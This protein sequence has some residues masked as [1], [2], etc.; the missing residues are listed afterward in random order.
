MYQNAFW[1]ESIT[2]SGGGGGG[3]GD[4]GLAEEDVITIIDEYVTKPYV[5]NL[6]IPGEP[7]T[8]VPSA[9]VPGNAAVADRIEYGNAAELEQLWFM[10][11]MGGMGASL[12]TNFNAVRQYTR[13]QDAVVEQR[14]ANT[15]YQK[16]DTVRLAQGL[17]LTYVQ[18]QLGSQFPSI[19]ADSMN[20]L[21]CVTPMAPLVPPQLFWNY[22]SWDVASLTGVLQT[23]ERAEVWLLNE[24]TVH[25]CTVILWDE[26][27]GNSASG[28]AY[29]SHM[30][31]SLP[32]YSVGVN[33]RCFDIPPATL[34]R[35]LYLRTT[36]RALANQYV[37][38]WALT[39]AHV[40]R[41]IQADNADA[42]GGT[43]ATGFYLK[44]DTV[45]NAAQA[46]NAQYL[47]GVDASG[48]LRT[49][50][51][52][53][54]AIGAN[55]S[56]SA[57]TATSATTAADASKLGGVSPSGYYL[58]TDT[59]TNAV[60]AQTA[61]D[62]DSLGGVLAAD[63]LK[64]SETASAAN[65]ATYANNSG[66]LGG[67]LAS[68][69]AL[70]SELGS[71]PIVTI[72]GGTSSYAQ[73][74]HVNKTVLIE[75][76]YNQSYTYWLNNNTMSGV[77]WSALGGSIQLINHHVGRLYVGAESATVVWRFNRSTR[78]PDSETYSTNTNGCMT[79]YVM[80]YNGSGYEWSITG[81]VD[82]N[83]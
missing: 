38:Q 62:T 30:I 24:S 55:H 27:A 25:S 28:T 13:D 71:R 1:G 47:G 15:Y 49:D 20:K 80:F 34:V 31:T 14:V 83:A 29:F 6:G 74:S 7:S 60:H 33:Q 2:P 11:S 9:N 5:V 70:K 58:K 23:N 12:E 17:V 82:V 16:T 10:L 68:G 44:T 40:P 36:P 69:Y 26:A 64:K 35:F 46:V 37:H 18:W 65:Y 54:Y 77:D 75:G 22:V 59:V 61:T 76:D 57:D 4:G 66:Y 72:T 48:F 19:T 78:I 39:G 67:V 21:F 42:L 63:Y 81:D 3:G 53:L 79:L 52:A 41:A 32:S 56:V 45:A 50:E 8:I 43:P 51:T 73:P